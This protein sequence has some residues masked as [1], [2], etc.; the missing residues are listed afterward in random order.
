MVRQ[1][2]WTA[3]ARRRHQIVAITDQLQMMEFTSARP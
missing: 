2:R 1:Y 3:H